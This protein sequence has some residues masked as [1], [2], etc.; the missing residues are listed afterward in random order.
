LDVITESINPCVA[1]LRVALLANAQ[2]VVPEPT[3]RAKPARCCRQTGSRI[4]I[5]EV[6]GPVDPSVLI[7]SGEKLLVLFI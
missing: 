6:N 3:L 7:V 4:R 2:I 1:E 5:F